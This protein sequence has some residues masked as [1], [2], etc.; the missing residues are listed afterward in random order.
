M[1]SLNLPNSFSAGSPAVAAEVNENFNSVKAFVEA[2]TVQRDGSVKTTASSYG[3]G[4]IN[5]IAL[6]ESSV[7]ND[8]INYSSVPQMTVATTDPVGGKNGD[9]WVKVIVP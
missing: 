2:E 6:A 9:I 1:A 4:S 8:K 3:D 5:T 7:T